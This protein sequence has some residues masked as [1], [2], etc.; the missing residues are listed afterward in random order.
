MVKR[1]TLAIANFLLIMLLLAWCTRQEA[2]IKDLKK[3]I[4][5]IEKQRYVT[6]DVAKQR[7]AFI[8]WQIQELGMTCGDAISIAT[9]AYDMVEP[10]I[11]DYETEYTKEELDS[12]RSSASVKSYAMMWGLKSSLEKID[13]D[14]KRSN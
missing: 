11:L 12:I 2:L 10:T 1:D 9:S 8:D 14:Q 13:K 5:Y 6:W 3:N 4:S 7:A